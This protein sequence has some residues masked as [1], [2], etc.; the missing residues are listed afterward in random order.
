MYGLPDPE[1]LHVGQD[2]GGAERAFAYAGAMLQL[3]PAP[4]VPRRHAENVWGIELASDPV[5]VGEQPSTRIRWVRA[6]VVLTQAVLPPGELEKKVGCMDYADD[7]CLQAQA[8]IP[9]A[10][11]TAAV[12]PDMPL[13]HTQ[14]AANGI[15]VRAYALQA[16]CTGA[17]D[18][19]TPTGWEDYVLLVR[20]KTEEAPPPSYC[21]LNARDGKE[22]SGHELEV[23][24]KLL[25]FCMESLILDAASDTS[26]LLSQVVQLF[27]ADMVR[28]PG[29]GN[30]LTRPFRLPGDSSQQ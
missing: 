12:E 19:S 18:S 22:L 2:V 16:C 7:S 11:G 30:V 10:T 26:G 21:A 13:S 15:E 25:R 5:D 27:E 9:E 8:I 28:V 4:N 17:L 3:F 29:G 23:V 20:S 14:R 6:R 1:T 24:A